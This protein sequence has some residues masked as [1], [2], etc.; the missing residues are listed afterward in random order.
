[1]GTYRPATVSERRRYGVSH[2]LTG[3]KWYKSS[4][5]A[6]VY[7]KLTSVSWRDEARA[8]K[9]QHTRAL[10]APQRFAL[11]GDGDHTRKVTHAHHA[12]DDEL[13][14]ALCE[15]RYRDWLAQREAAAAEPAPASP[16]RARTRSRQHASAATY[17]PS[18]IDRAYAAWAGA[19]R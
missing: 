8:R 17:Q 7:P 19:D 10:G 9:A 16:K 5:A 11:T 13:K 14:V 2:R 6:C 18:A 3:S 1:M 4:H 12:N 15:A